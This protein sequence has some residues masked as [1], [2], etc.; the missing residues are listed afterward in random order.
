MKKLTFLASSFLG[1]SAIS[2]Q[3]AIIAFDIQGKGGI[4]LLSTNENTA[5]IG[6]FGSGGE[7]GAG[8]S[9]NDVSNELTINVAWGSANGFTDLSGNA[10][11]GHVHGPNLSGGA[12]SFLQNATVAFPLDSGG[13]WNPSA[14]AGGVTGRV[15]T[16]TDIQETQ[17]LDGKFY[18]NFHTSV[19][20]TGEI[21]G[22]LV[23]PEPST[24]VLGALGMMGLLVRKRR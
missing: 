18:L 1:L 20:P 23:V 15:L 3:A 13:T 22:N 19:N 24:A 6:A 16:L 4:G 21:R 2:S 17:L 8:I 14:S 11:A 10:T 5:V 9:Y 12:A 7:V